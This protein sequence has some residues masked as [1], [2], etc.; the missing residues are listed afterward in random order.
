LDCVKEEVIRTQFLAVY[1]TSISDSFVC[2]YT[3]TYW[4]QKLKTSK[5][6]K[7]LIVNALLF[8]ND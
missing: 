8:P 6:F 2:M 5:Y 7:E 1:L 4:L 3:Y